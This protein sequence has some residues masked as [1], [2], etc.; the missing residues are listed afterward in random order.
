MLSSETQSFHLCLSIEGTLKQHESR[1]K[2]LLIV[3]GKS[4][5]G[6]ELKGFLRN[7]K[8]ANPTHVVFSPCGNV[9]EKGYCLGHSYDQLG[10]MP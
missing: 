6:A 1:I 4:L 2:D 8:K 7:Y 3:D 10:E 5:S 9:S